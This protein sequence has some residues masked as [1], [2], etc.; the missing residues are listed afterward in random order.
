[1]GLKTLQTL[2]SIFP[3]LCDSEKEA[4]VNVAQSFLRHVK[5]KVHH[6]KLFTD[7][8]AAE[9]AKHLKLWH[10]SSSKPL[11]EDAFLEALKDS[12]EA[13]GRKVSEPEAHNH[14]GEDLTVDSNRISLKRETGW[15]VK[16]EQMHI[17]KLIEAGWLNQPDA[18]S[19]AI[20]KTV[21]HLTLYDI[22]LVLRAFQSDDEITYHVV[23][24]PKPLLEQAGRLTPDD[25][26]VWKNGL[27]LPMTDK[28][29]RYANVPYGECKAAWQLYLDGSDGKVSLKNIRTEFCVVHATWTIPLDHRTSSGTLSERP[30]CLPAS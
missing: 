9:F 18:N 17:S 12:F 7:R 6:S 27:K 22:I 20:Q 4:V 24:I 10:R 23:E 8:S 15:R 26:G 25:F 19:I 2:F 29:T 14:K 21:H 5:Y 3:N 13:D 30:A 16:P 28:R 1:M 11:S